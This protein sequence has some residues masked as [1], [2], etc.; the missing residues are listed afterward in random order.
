MSAAPAT[1]FGRCRERLERA[2]EPTCAP[3]RDWAD[4]VARAIRA[5]VEFAADDPPAARTLT[6]HASSRWREREPEFSAL[7]EHFSRLLD[8]DAPDRN[9]RLPDAP[10]VVTRIARQLNLQLE[11]GRAGEVTELVPDLTFLALMPYVGFA[12]ARRWAE[13]AQAARG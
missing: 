4:N 6:A 12:G 3:G 2:L 1:E 8:L 5:V 10:T 7:V 9:A 13:P 11:T